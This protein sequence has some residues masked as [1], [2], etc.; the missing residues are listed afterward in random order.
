MREHR[1]TN[2]YVDDILV[3]SCSDG[4]KFVLSFAASE[5]THIED[6]REEVLKRYRGLQLNAGTH[7][8]VD[9]LTTP[10]SK[11]SLIYFLSSLS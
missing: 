9:Q 10:D 2:P 1:A 7:V 6:L 11:R 8:R 3:S 5:T 4:I